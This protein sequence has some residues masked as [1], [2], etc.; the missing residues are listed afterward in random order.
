M[1]PL[2]L[3]SVHLWCCTVFLLISCSTATHIIK[4][5][6]IWGVKRPPQIPWYGLGVW[7]PSLFVYLVGI[8]QTNC[9]SL[10]FPS[11][12]G[13]IFFSSEKNQIIFGWVCTKALQLGELSSCLSRSVIKTCMRNSQY[14]YAV[15]A[16]LVSWLVSFMAYQP[17]RLFNAKSMF[18]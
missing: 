5:I 8:E 15:D 13:G 11:D 12:P 7:F 6:A 14:L 2:S 18:M 16:W 17:Y 1:L 4:E 3:P 10:S 9:C